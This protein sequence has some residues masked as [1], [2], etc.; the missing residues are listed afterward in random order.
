M[1][2]SRE[3]V[4]ETG[5]TNVEDLG[6]YRTS[7]S[8]TWIDIQGLGDEGLLRRLAD[9]FSIH[10]LV[11]ADIVNVPQRPKLSVVPKGTA[12]VLAKTVGLQAGPVPDL[13][14]ACMRQ[15]Y[16]AR[17]RPLDVGFIDDTAFACFVGFGFD[18]SSAVAA[19]I[20][21]DWQ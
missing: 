18:A 21:P 8:I 6:A 14:H 7:P 4:H 16:W 15:L 2:Y 12:N 17:E 5:V 10:P 11:L 20:M 1:D 9:L 19:M 3:C 13:L